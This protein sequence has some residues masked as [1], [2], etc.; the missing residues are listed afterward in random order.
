MDLSKPKEDKNKKEKKAVKPNDDKQQEDRASFVSQPKPKLTPDISN[1][2]NDERGDEFIPEPPKERDN[3]RKKQNKSSFNRV[4]DA[5][6]KARTYYN[7]FQKARKIVDAIKNFGRSP[8]IPEGLSGT[9]PEAGAEVGGEA[10]TGAAGEIAAAGGEIAAEAGAE[11]AASVGTELGVGVA[12][13]GGEAAASTLGEAAATGLTES[14]GAGVTEAG[15]TGLAEGVGAGITEGI[16]AGITEG[17]AAAGAESVAAGAA[18]ATTGALGAAAAGTTTAVGGAAAGATGAAATAATTAATAAAGATTAAAATS[19]A[20]GTVAV[21]IIVVVMII[22]FI[23][24]IINGAPT[25]GNSDNKPPVQFACISKNY[26]QCMADQFGIKITGDSG[27][28]TTAKTKILYDIFSIPAVYSLYLQKIKHAKLSIHLSRDYIG[29]GLVANAHAWTNQTTYEIT[30]FNIFFSDQPSTQKYILIH[31]SG[32]V[33]EDDNGVLEP[34]LSAQTRAGTDKSCYKNYLLKTF[35]A[36]LL[37]NPDSGRINRESFAEAVSNS[38]I[39]KS[40]QVCPSNGGGGSSIQDFPKTCSNTYNFMLKNVL[41]EITSSDGSD[42]SQSDLYA[43]ATSRPTSS[44]CGEKYNFGTI[45]KDFPN[46]KN[47]NFGDPVCNYSLANFRKV[48]EQTETNPQNWDFWMD[49]AYAESGS[50]NGY[51][52]GSIGAWGRFQM[53]P[54]YTNQRPDPGK[55]WTE[56]KNDRGDVPWQKQIANAVSYNNDLTKNNSSFDYWGTAMCLC[57]Y[58]KYAGKSYCQ[59]LRKLGHVRS[60]TDKRCNNSHIKELGNKN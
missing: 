46:L 25:Q 44:T 45:K 57:A 20:W 28:I 31:E 47:A 42:S 1:Q 36:N 34:A 6:N 55:Q 33:I 19:P 12:E 3:Q 21:V 56:A 54:G 16:G 27:Q 40:G 9:L 10:I 29:T 4:Y 18:G 50:P 39:C 26:Q 17:A 30:L 32:H 41:G 35:P 51:T 22:T 49:I 15:A 5:F 13:A 23:I 60:T 14:V 8:S 11:T 52:P 48:I 58:P 7:R 2:E 37:V 59:D 38:V 43:G 24:V 53:R